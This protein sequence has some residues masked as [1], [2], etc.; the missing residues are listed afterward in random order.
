MKRCL[1]KKQNKCII[2]LNKSDDRGS[3]LVTVIVIVAFVS[4]LAT[5]MLYLAGENY[6]TKAIDQKTKESFYEAE[7]VVELFKT[8]LV[9]DVAKAA[10]EAY[11]ATNADYIKSEGDAK[12]L[13]NIRE[14]AYLENFNTAFHKVWEG[15]FVTSTIDGRTYTP[16]ENAV[17]ELI[18]GSSVSSFDETNGKCIFTINVGS[19]SVALTCTINDLGN[20][21]QYKN[22]FPA[23]T[24]TPGSAPSVFDADGK[25][26]KYTIENLQITVTD[27][28]KYSSVIQTSFEITPPNVNWNSE[29]SLIKDSKCLTEIDYTECVQYKNWRRD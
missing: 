26:R 7:E 17:L 9:V 5:I 6:K 2:G 11:I 24:L 4:I 23:E 8:Q 19:P 27:S 14:K 20:T 1:F 21:F 25:V 15:H 29:E 12:T 10:Q 3:T 16:E 13:A 22:A 18:K 28:R